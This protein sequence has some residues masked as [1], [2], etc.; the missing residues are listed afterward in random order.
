VPINRDALGAR[1]V[2]TR[3][4]WTSF[5]SIL[6]AV[7]VGAGSDDALDE[8]EFTTENTAG[9][10]QQAL[11]S[12]A[13]VLIPDGAGL[14]LVGP[15][16]WTQVVHA[17][18]GIVF[19]RCLPVEG[20]L[21]SVTEVAAIHDKGTGALVVTQT[22]AVVVGTREP[23][24]S[25]RMSAFVR[26]AGGWGGDR[27]PSKPDQ[28]E[29]DREPDLILTAATA[30]SQ[31]LLYRLSGDRNRLHSDPE[32]AAAAG[33]ERPILHGLC[34]YGFTCR[35]LLR[36]LAIAPSR[37]ISMDTRF[38]SPVFPGEPLTVRAWHDGRNAVRFETCGADRRVIMS[39]GHLVFS[40]P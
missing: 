33:F 21:E 9:V 36:A 38:R 29:L 16:D 27:G 17:E 8:L 11:P 15:I 5:E 20:E 22:D 26:G 10:R 19:H 7:G 2:S 13:T 31:A 1:T 3:R 25:S 35:L 34:T 39:G 4:A 14:D 6:Y 30:P 24:F 37:L 32:F 28:V 23:L 40:E 18:Q 12:M